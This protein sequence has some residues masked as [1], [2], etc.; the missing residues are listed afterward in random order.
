MVELTS[1]ITDGTLPLL[2]PHEQGTQGIPPGKVWFGRIWCFSPVSQN[3]HLGDHFFAAWFSPETLHHRLTPRFSPGWLFWQKKQGAA[4]KIHKG[5]FGSLKDCRSGNS[6]MRKD[7]EQPKTQGHNRIIPFFP[8]T[9]TWYIRNGNSSPKKGV[10][11][12]QCSTFD[13]A[14]SATSE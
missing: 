3:D 6:S 2:T 7:A 11:H 5:S 14:R 8:G 4:K 10:E 12:T 13:K 9:N 1:H